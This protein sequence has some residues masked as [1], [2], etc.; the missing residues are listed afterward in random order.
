MIS[1]RTR[2]GALA[3]LACLATLAAPAA[4]GASTPLDGNG[5]WIWYVNRSGGTAGKIAAKAKAHH[6][7]TVFVKSSDGKNAWSQF[8]KGFVKRLHQQGLK[9]CA[10]AFVYGDNPGAEAR[11]SAE[12]KGKG[13]DC[14][15]IDAETAYEGKYRAADHYMTAL[16]RAVGPKYPLALAGFPYVDY[17]PS[18]PYSVFFR[19]PPSALAHGPAK[20]SDI[21]RVR[22]DVDEVAV[23]AVHEEEVSVVRRRLRV[24]DRTAEHEEDALGLSPRAT[25]ASPS[26]RE[27]SAACPGPRSPA[28][29]PAA[30]AGRPAAA[31]RT[32]T[33]ARSRRRA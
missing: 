9:V 25:R 14:L 6:V 30:W 26:A 33:A 22:R 8:T 15:I 5:M 13:A 11:R 31:R 23:R 18:F 3:L 29:R 10:W 4:A 28:R 19:R 16:R 12:V 20:T 32:P 24:A 2:I 1:H 7:R 21:E 17:H 27:P